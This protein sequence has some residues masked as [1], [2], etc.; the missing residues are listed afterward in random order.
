MIYMVVWSGGYEAPS[1]SLYH[2]E[3]AAFK[4][5]NNWW[6]DADKESD[7]MDVLAIDIK[8]LEVKRL[9]QRAWTPEGEV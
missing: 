3:K 5:A 9:E 6:S 1:Y 8:T 4:Q 2:N 7:S